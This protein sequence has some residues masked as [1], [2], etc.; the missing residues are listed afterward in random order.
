M[1]RVLV[2][3]GTGF[4]GSRLAL[5]CRADGNDVR[6][7]SPC[8]TPGEEARARELRAAGVELVDASVTDAGAVH[9]ACAGVDTLYHLA[10]AQHEANVPDQYFYDVNVEG[11]RTVLRAAADAGITRVVHGST[12]G[13]YGVGRGG[14]VTDDTPL[15]PDNIYGIT[16]LAGE[17]LAI[18]MADR[19]PV[20]IV[21]ISETYGPG[22]GRLLKLFRGIAAGRFVMIGP[23]TNL[24]HPVYVDDLVDGL[25]Q[26]AAMPA[27]AGRVMVCAGPDVVTTDEMVAAIAAAVGLHPP[28]LRVPLAPL[29]A[30]AMVLESTLGRLGVQPP[31][32]RRRMNF[33]IKSFRFTGDTAREL[34]GY[35]PRVPFA[36]GA[37]RTAAWYR[38]RGLL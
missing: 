16:K 3:G 26:A 14:P 19:L 8:R 34:I 25:R 5:R 38:E 18:E 2:T 7:L 33:F 29:L 9:L 22:D 21:R 24:H 32:H 12:I 37:A 36:E 11:T 10:A 17:R 6:V 15:E 31:L 35:A 13:V 28:R 30:V 20:A 23:G 1:S 4:I 27:A